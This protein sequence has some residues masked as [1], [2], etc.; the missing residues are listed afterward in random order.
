MLCLENL[1]SRQ[2]VVGSRTLVLPQ[3]PGSLSFHPVPTS[4]VSP[5]F[6]FYIAPTSFLPLHHPLVPSIQFESLGTLASLLP[7]N[8]LLDS[9]F[10]LSFVGG[11][12]LYCLRFPSIPPSGSRPSYFVTSAQFSLAFL[13]TFRVDRF[14]SLVVVGAEGL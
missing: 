1:P 13:H 8:S 7:P 9:P 3:L 6:P 12:S 14:S 11:I 10:L 4:L 5:L 2:M